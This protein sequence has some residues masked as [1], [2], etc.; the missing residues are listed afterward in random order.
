MLNCYYFIW[1]LFYHLCVTGTWCLWLEIKNELGRSISTLLSLKAFLYW[2]SVYPTLATWFKSFSWRWTEHVFPWLC[3]P[4]GSCT[5]VTASV[6]SNSIKRQLSLNACFLL[7]KNKFLGAAESKSMR[8]RWSRPVVKHS[9]GAKP[10]G[11]Q[12]KLLS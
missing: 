3:L 8:D 4:N 6:L 10:S 9:S 5:D 7:Q 12:L 1:F 2:N 11:D